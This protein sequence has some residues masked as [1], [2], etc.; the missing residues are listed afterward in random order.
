MEPN[1]FWCRG[2]QP[3][4]VRLWCGAGGPNQNTCICSLVPGAPAKTRA[5]VVWCRGPQPK[6]VRLWFGAGGPNQNTCV[7]GVVPEAPT[8]TRASVVWCR[9]PQP[10]HVSNPVHKKHTVNFIYLLRP[11]IINIYYLMDARLQTSRRTP[12]SDPSS[13]RML[14]ITESRRPG[15]GARDTGLIFL[16]P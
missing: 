14:R 5:S 16:P 10:K 3:K 11:L 1:T 6:H 13:A 15:K 8:K 4:H 9:G 2:S 7:C 12:R